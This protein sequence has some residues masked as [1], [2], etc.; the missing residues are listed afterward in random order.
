MNMRKKIIF[1]AV[2][3]IVVTNV[4]SQTSN[5]IDVFIDN[6][7]NTIKDKE[8]NDDSMEKISYFFISTP[9]NE[10]IIKKIMARNYL[11]I[12]YKINDIKINDNYYLVEIYVHQKYVHSNGSGESRGIKKFNLVQDNSVFK[13][14]DTD[15]TKTYVW[16]IFLILGLLLVIFIPIFIIITKK[17]KA[18]LNLKR[19]LPEL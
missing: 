11:N 4:Y 19:K 1:I 10:Q 7:F 9:E 16:L 8:I 15:F 5:E 13:I 14:K 3:L 17:L 18:N 6:F 12:E 2:L